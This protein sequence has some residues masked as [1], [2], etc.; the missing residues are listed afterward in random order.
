LNGSLVVDIVGS[1][2]LA[3]AVAND[4]DVLLGFTVLGS[5]ATASAQ[6]NDGTASE[7][8]AGDDEPRSGIFQLRPLVAVEA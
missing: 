5:L 3:D 2:A 8:G 4:G 6:A 1:T 7:T